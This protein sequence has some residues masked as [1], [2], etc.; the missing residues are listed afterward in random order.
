MQGGGGA[1]GG[2]QYFVRFLLTGAVLVL[3]ARSEYISLWGAI[4][5]IFTLQ[6]AAYML[7]IFIARDA[8]KLEGGQKNDL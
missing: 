2:G 5:G 6:I 4:A 3:A 7:R 8:V 1:Y